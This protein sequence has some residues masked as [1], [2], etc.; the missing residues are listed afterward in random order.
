MAMPISS[1]QSLP[2]RMP[3]LGLASTSKILFPIPELTLRLS[4]CDLSLTYRTD[5]GS[6]TTALRTM[7][8]LSEAEI[9]RSISLLGLIERVAS[10]LSICGEVRLIVP[11]GCKPGST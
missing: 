9:I 3:D 11:N 1:G 2:I 5:K 7:Q 6:G 10:M 4:G 8:S